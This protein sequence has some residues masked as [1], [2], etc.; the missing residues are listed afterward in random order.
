MSNRPPAPGTYD[1]KDWKCPGCKTLNFKK[2]RT[3]L[4][5]ATDRP[6]ETKEET[7]PD[8][9]TGKKD[10]GTNVHADWTCRP[11]GRFNVAEDKNCIQCDSENP[12]A[13]EDIAPP[14][15]GDGRSGNRGGHFDRPDPDE[16]KKDWNSDDEDVDEF[17]RK[18]KSKK[19]ASAADKQKAALERLKAKTSGAKT[20]GPANRRSRS[21][22]RSRS[23]TSTMRFSRAPA[24]R[25]WLPQA[26]ACSQVSQAGFSVQAS[27]CSEVSQLRPLLR[28]L[29]DL[30]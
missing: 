18:K 25:L 15:D 4:S 16:K 1:P 12:N 23:L 5:C 24:C 7:L 27:T 28:L 9:R 13:V 30:S 3:C 20:S 21:R 26:P 29:F 2:R 22:S 17:G 14:V 6:R 11:C 8:W 10:C 19:G